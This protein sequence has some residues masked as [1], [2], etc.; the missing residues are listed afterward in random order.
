MS[1]LR[2]LDR[3][4]IT[5]PPK[6]TVADAIQIMLD[7]RVGSVVIVEAKKV[8]GIFTERDVLRKLALSC[9][10]PKSV[11]VSELMTAPAITVDPEISPADALG[12]MLEHHFRHLP[13]VDA[14]GRLRGVLSIRNLLQEMMEK[15]RHQLHSLEQYVISEEPGATKA[16]G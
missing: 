3:E 15:Y 10:D 16:R 7:R 13:V 5:V 8:L 11:A 14:R 1:I 12:M 4:S 2:L 9:R 6:T